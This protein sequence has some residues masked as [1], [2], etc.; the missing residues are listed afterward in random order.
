[1]NSVFSLR[2]VSFQYSQK[3]SQKN[4]QG[5]GLKSIS[6]AI[7]PGERVALVGRSGAGKSTLLNLLNGSLSPSVGELQILGQPIAHLPQRQ[8]R[9]L[10]FQIGTI[11]QQLFLVDNLP[12]IHNVNAGNLGRWTFWQAAFS[13]L[14]PLGV[15]R[16]RQVL[17]QVGIPEKIF[18][19]TDRLSGG[20]QQ[21]VAIARVL[22]QNPV[23]ILA[24]EP[25]ASLDPERSREVMDLLVNLCETNGKTL[26]VSLHNLTYARSHCQRAIG[27]KDGEIVFDLAIAEL[28]DERIAEL[29]S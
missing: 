5:T 14:F 3:Y 21:R 25:I 9:R 8:R 1:M 6:L 12:V 10:Q 16:V 4:I 27:L 11:Y 15:D 18:A 17:Q 13:L 26:V 7:A 24:D 22:I 28:T 19:R 2:Q 23:A 20:E 29:Y